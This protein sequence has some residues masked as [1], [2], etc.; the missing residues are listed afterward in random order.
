MRFYI[1]ILSL[2]CFSIIGQPQKPIVVVIPSYNNAAWYKRNLDSVCSQ[3]YDNYRIIYIDDCS[4][5]GTG[6]LV[7]AYIDEHTLHD[8]VTL[9]CNETNC[10]AMFNH[11]RAVWMCQDH[12]IIVHIDGDDWLKHDDVLER[13]NQTYQDP[14]VWMT[15]G[16]FERYPDGAR[17]YCRPLPA[18]VVQ[19]NMFR[20]YDWLTSH[21]RTFY[22]G[23][24]KQIALKDFLYGS[25]YFRC[26]CDMAMFFPLLELAGYHVRCIDE[27]LYVYNEQTTLNDYKVNLLS[28]LH[29]DKVIRSRP[30]YHLT[31]TYMRTVASDKVDALVFFDYQHDM[32]SLLDILVES[33]AQVTLLYHSKQQADIGAYESQF[34]EVDFVCFDTNLADIIYRVASQDGYVLCVKDRYNLAKPLLLH[35]AIRMLE[36][37]Q[38]LSFHFSLGKYSIKHTS[39]TRNQKIPSL[40]RVP[41]AYYAWW[42]KDAEFDWRQPY[43]QMCLY[44]KSDLKRY[45]EGTMFDNFDEL[46]HILTLSAVDVEQLGI[47]F[48]EDNITEY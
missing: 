48:N 37:T 2:L 23:L 15:Y 47:C 22:A 29:C 10:G 18:A 46:M 24:F 33:G 36:Q 19:R 20:E 41:P 25:D 42:Y 16:Q 32:L 4:T 34:P 7:Q 27:I 5:D 26:T 39:L 3:H 8:K 14:Q 17:G 38:A 35:D 9:I 6:K 40:M 31:R 45:I 43:G 1:Y 28:Q 11:Y 44:R 12:E 21:L 30:K 13:I